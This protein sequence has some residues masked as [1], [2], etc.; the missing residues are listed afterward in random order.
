MNARDLDDPRG[1]LRF[2]GTFTVQSTTGVHHTYRIRTDKDLGRRVSLLV[3]PDNE[4]SWASFAVIH[5]RIYSTHVGHAIVLL[6]A[7]CMPTTS[8]P[9]QRREWFEGSFVG[10]GLVSQWQRHAA[11]LADL[12]SPDGVLRVRG[13][14]VMAATLCR[15]CNR[16]L[17]V[18]ASIE[19]G[20]GPDCAELE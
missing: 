13:F 11:T 8:P 6:P 15:R 17:T 20:I 19:S 3:G 2:N 14:R 4:S 1:M 10:R 7:C 5:S 9:E 18:P 12:D 16:T